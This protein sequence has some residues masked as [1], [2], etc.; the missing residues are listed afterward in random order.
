MRVKASSIYRH[1]TKL[2]G[3]FMIRI[4]LLLLINAAGIY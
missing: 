2:K 1:T 4:A 3:Y